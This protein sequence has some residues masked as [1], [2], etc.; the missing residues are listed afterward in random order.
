LSELACVVWP[1][2]ASRALCG[3]RRRA[4]RLPSNGVAASSVVPTNSTLWTFE[5]S[6]LTGLDALAGQK[7][8][9][10]LYQALSQVMNG[11]RRNV[12]QLSRSHVLQL[13]GHWV[14]VHCTAL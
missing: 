5:P 8:H 3:K 9:G 11:A 4:S 13:C 14:S 7:R 2:S 12:R 10:A 6:T 1:T